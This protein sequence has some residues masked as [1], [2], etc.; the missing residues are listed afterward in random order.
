M[1]AAWCF[2]RSRKVEYLF[3]EAESSPN[4]LVLP[5]GHVE[6]GERHSETAV[7]K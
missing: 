2:V 4:E 7:R 3:V 6:E 1:L 5:K